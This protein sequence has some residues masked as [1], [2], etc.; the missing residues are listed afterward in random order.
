MIDGLTINFFNGLLSGL[1]AAASLTSPLPAHVTLSP[2]AARSFTGLPHVSYGAIPMAPLFDSMAQLTQGFAAA[3]QSPYRAAMQGVGGQP[4]VYAIDSS[5]HPVS[6]AGRFVASIVAA[7]AG[8]NGDTQLKT[9]SLFNTDPHTMADP[10]AS[11]VGGV[12]VLP[13]SSASSQVGY[14]GRN[15]GHAAPANPYA[16][17]P[18]NY[19]TSAVGSDRYANKTAVSVTAGEPPPA[20]SGSRLQPTTR[21]PSYPIK[22]FT[23]PPVTV[24]RPQLPA[25]TSQSRDMPPRSAYIPVE[26]RQSE[27]N[28]PTAHSNLQRPGDD[29]MQKLLLS[30]GPRGQV[31]AVSV[32]RSIPVTSFTSSSPVQMAQA[33]AT[34][35][36]SQNL[37]YVDPARGQGQ[38]VAISAYQNYGIASPIQY[39]PIGYVPPAEDVMEELSYDDVSSPEGIGL[40]DAAGSLEGSYLHNSVIGSKEDA[41]NV[42][43]S[44]S[45]HGANRQSSLVLG[46]IAAIADPTIQAQADS[47]TRPKK[48]GSAGRAGRAASGETL[49]ER[50][51]KRSRSG[52][53]RSRAKGK[54]EEDVDSA[55]VQHRAIEM[56]V[57][58][59]NA[60]VST[61]ACAQLLPTEFG[62]PASQSYVTADAFGQYRVL[63]DPYQ[64]VAA[65]CMIAPGTRPD[66]TQHRMGT[67]STQIDGMVRSDLSSVQQQEAQVFMTNMFGNT[68]VNPNEPMSVEQ[69]TFVDHSDT[70]SAMYT[71]PVAAIPKHDPKHRPII[72]EE[73]GHLADDPLPG[74]A[75]TTST[76]VHDAVQQPLLVNSATSS[77]VDQP[78]SLSE[79]K[80]SKPQQSSAFMDSFMNFIQ[81]K[82][83]ETLASVSTSVV[84]KKPVLPKYIPEPPRPKPPPTPATVT[85]SASAVNSKPAP[86]TNNISDA[87]VVQFSDDEDEEPMSKRIGSNI[88]NAVN[89]VLLSLNKPDSISP[90]KT[91]VQ[92]LTTGAGKPRGRSSKISPG[93]PNTVKVTPLSKSK[94]VTK[95]PRVQKRRSKTEKWVDGGV[96]SDDDGDVVVVDSPVV[97]PRERSTRKAK[98]VASQRGRAAKAHKGEALVSSF[99]LSFIAGLVY[100]SSFGGTFNLYLLSLQL[101]ILVSCSARSLQTLFK[102]CCGKHNNAYI[103]NWILRVAFLILLL[104]RV[105]YGTYGP[106]GHY[107]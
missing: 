33:L 40:Q 37:S 46:R 97:P 91:P 7:T 47:T 105:I 18:T 52:S 107:Q 94:P 15:S 21:T 26:Q 86:S 3:S 74:T 89:K 34:V 48:G 2:A 55:G 72:E 50:G 90:A 32:G 8:G 20:H 1:G 31:Q 83:P 39:A 56:A 100:N 61:A 103:V 35:G 53:S 84:T 28:P 68:F 22:E 4:T 41:R 64:V 79:S 54:T 17:L 85:S 80:S 9:V 63:S 95:K 36:R 73:F 106:R 104:N 62:S 42:I 70:A 51:G 87:I 67:I 5:G 93:D 14:G 29:L 102:V 101:R 82:K 77:A 43:Q 99:N 65:E 88:T 49:A 96:V 12:T 71:A 11:S 75:S 6:S 59:Y 81:G 44:C 69:I 25:T 27:A 24:Q 60:Y 58:D 78:K 13:S 23:Q 45:A 10:V 66:I 98:E 19:T 57:P 76:V 92:H 16:G 30:Y 38:R